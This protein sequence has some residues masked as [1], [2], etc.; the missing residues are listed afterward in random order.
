[1]I[2]GAKETFA[3]PRLSSEKP[4]TVGCTS[5]GSSPISVIWS[6]NIEK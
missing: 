5:L 4:Q 3:A 6:K 2:A 1:V